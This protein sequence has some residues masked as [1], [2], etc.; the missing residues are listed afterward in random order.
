MIKTLKAATNMPEL[1]FICREHN[2]MP[3]LTESV[4]L[5]MMLTRVLYEQHPDETL[6]LFDSG[7]LLEIVSYDDEKELLP[8]M[9]LRQFD[10][11][12]KVDKEGKGEPI[13]QQDTQTQ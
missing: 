10:V 5:G 12:Y 4:W 6:A 11:G 7:T 2:L 13:C 3:V 1:L 9:K 8:Y